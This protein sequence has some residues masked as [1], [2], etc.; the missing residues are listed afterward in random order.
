MHKF[1]SV[2]L[3]G[4]LFIFN[5][6]AEPPPLTLPKEAQKAFDQALLDIY[7]QRFNSEIHTGTDME[8]AFFMKLK[9]KDRNE[10]RPIL[11]KLTE[12]PKLSRDGDMLVFT[13]KTGTVY[14]KWPDLRRSQFYLGKTSWA[15]DSSSPLKFQIELFDQKVKAEAKRPQQTSSIFDLLIPRAE[16]LAPLAAIGV[17][18][19]W[20][21]SNPSC[22]FVVLGLAGSVIGGYG[23]DIKEGTYKLTCASIA[24]LGFKPW[25]STGVCRPW[26]LD[27]DN[28]VKL[29]RAKGV[30][31][32]EKLDPNLRWVVAGKPECPPKND[33]GD[34]VF[35]A[36]MA[37]VKKDDKGEWKAVGW[38]RFEGKLNPKGQLIEA[39]TYK[40]EEDEKSPNKK[41]LATATFNFTKDP[42]P[43]VESISFP[44]K[45]YNRNDVTSTPTVTI[46]LT[47]Q[48]HDVHPEYRDRMPKLYNLALAAQ[49]WA[50]TCK[51]LAFSAKFDR[52][53]AERTTREMQEQETVTPEDQAQS[54]K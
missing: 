36:W 17:G 21:A 53:Q 38:F 26:K 18:I 50:D 48:D 12:V 42:V 35:S 3:L 52:G 20:C 25:D 13:F 24:G 1:I 2:I 11:E 51:N 15:F 8:K 49:G 5:A 16:A 45:D 46:L 6:S 43:A 14:V 29:N 19:A 31:R 9:E 41:D 22:T 33:K 4:L 28:Q 34:E 47:D 10:V 54:K 32:P 23:G 37:E 7:I 39:A 30:A 27:Q 44:R 40:N